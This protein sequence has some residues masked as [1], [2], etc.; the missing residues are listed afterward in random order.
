MAVGPLKRT[1]G[2]LSGY[3]FPSNEF[4]A[5][6]TE[7]PLLRGVNVG[8]G[9][10][11]WDDVVYWSRTDGDRLDTWQL[12]T[13]D[14]VLGMDRPWIAE[15]LRIAQLIEQDVPSL[16][17]Q[18]VAAIRPTKRLLPEYLARLLEQDAFHHHC[19][20]EMTGVS[21]P[22]I[23]PGQIANF[24]VSLP[25]PEEQ[26]QILAEL[27]NF[28]ERAQ[29]LS[30]EAEAAVELLQER[31]AALISAAVTGKIDVRGLPAA[32]QDAQAA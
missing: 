17:L 14:V 19:V 2:V 28:A 10:T 27:S 1:V 7:T 23:S 5:D 21:V 3:A 18:R 26:A 32:S 22:H 8:V 4:S 15:G 11:R 29:R 9:G 30:S 6:P 31:R 25:P 12:R 20:P 24:I 13:G 16:L